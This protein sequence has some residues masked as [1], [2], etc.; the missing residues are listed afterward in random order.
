[1]D[2]RDQELEGILENLRGD[3][4]SEFELH[5]WEDAAKKLDSSLQAKPLRKQV[6]RQLAAVLVGALLGATGVLSFTKDYKSNKNCGQQ[7]AS[8]IRVI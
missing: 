5:K 8:E 3:V 6:W 2:K 7:N 4:P 1:M